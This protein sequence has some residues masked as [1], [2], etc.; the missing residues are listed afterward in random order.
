MRKNFVLWCYVVKEVIKSILIKC[1]TAILC[2]N[3]SAGRLRL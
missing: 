1:C 2:D 3:F